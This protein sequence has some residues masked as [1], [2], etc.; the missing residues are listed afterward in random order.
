MVEDSDRHVLRAPDARGGIERKQLERIADAVA[1]LLVG[2]AT[3][4]DGG[5]FV[6]GE[7]DD[8]IGERGVGMACLLMGV[9][10]CRLDFLDVLAREV[11]IH[12]LIAVREAD[13]ELAPDRCGIGVDDF[14]SAVGI[15]LPAAVL[16]NA[17][18][19]FVEVEHPFPLF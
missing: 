15:A 8:L 14:E 13:V 9:R 10:L 6:I 17:R 5:I 2:D 4:A 3:H 12:Q 18:I 16:E 1:D 11:L 7:F 19:G